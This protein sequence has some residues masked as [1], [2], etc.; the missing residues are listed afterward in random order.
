M[1]KK[2]KVEELID[3]GKFYFLNGRFELAIDMFEKA[4]LIDRKNPEIYYNLGVVYEA[5]D[6]LKAIENFEMALKLKPGDKKIEKHLYR[7]KNIK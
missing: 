7:L 5:V 3:K 4:L 1:N 2:E 6:T